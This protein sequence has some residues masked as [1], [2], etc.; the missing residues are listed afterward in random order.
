MYLFPKVFV[1]ILN[2]IILLI[3]SKYTKYVILALDLGLKK[4]EK[5][6]IKIMIKL[7]Y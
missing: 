5:N 7:I 4:R 2:N 1:Y 6:I 3:F